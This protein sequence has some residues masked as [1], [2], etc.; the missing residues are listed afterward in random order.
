MST[1][2]RKKVRVFREGVSVALD[3]GATASFRRRTPSR[4]V[5]SVDRVLRGDAFRI[6]SDLGRVVSRERRRVG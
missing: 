1:N 5:V 2:F 6:G 3:L 4:V